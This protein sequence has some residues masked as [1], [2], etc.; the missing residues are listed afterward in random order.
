[1]TEVCLTSKQIEIRDMLVCAAHEKRLVYFSDVG[2]WVG[3]GALPA[4]G[5]LNPINQHEH[6]QGRPLLTAVVISKK[7]GKP[8]QGFFNFAEKELGID[9][10]PNKATFWVRELCKVFLAHEQLC[11]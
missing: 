3:L 10:G 11:K 9:V 7:T 5:L 6:E 8:G 4:A 2:D 1:M